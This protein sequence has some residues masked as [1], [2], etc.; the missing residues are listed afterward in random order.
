IVLTI[1]GVVL[2]MNQ[3]FFWGLFGLNL[4]TNQFLPLSAGLFLPIVLIA[5]PIRKVGQRRG[6]GPRPT[7]LTDA[8]N[9]LT[10]DNKRG[11]PWYDTVLV[12]AL[13]GSAGYFAYNGPAIAE[14]GWAFISPPVAT[15][16]SF[17]FWAL[18]LEVLRRAAGWVVM[19]L[20]LIVSLYPVIAE[21]IPVGFLQGITY[22]VSTLA[23][24]HVMGVES[25]F[26]LPMQ[27]AGIILVGFMFFGVA[28]QHT[29]G[30]DFFHQLS[31]A[32]F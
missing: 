10:R 26:G 14:F 15:V 27:T 6:Q 29:G 23:Q 21:G 9:Q 2:T 17:V 1:A 18:V 5:T 20:A 31:N 3:I 13:M 7:E 30:A 19:L 22:D 32:I 28:L 4:I 24:V 8:A 25:I 12:V 16:L 11:V